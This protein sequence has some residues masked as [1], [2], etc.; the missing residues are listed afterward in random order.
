MPTNV[1]T[2]FQPFFIDFGYRGIAFFA[3]VYGVVS[4]YL[5]RLFRNGNN[6][7]TCL[8]TYGVYVLLMQF[9][10]EN[11]FMSMVFILQFIVFTLLFTQN[12]IRF[13]W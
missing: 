4:G 2:I 1:Y 7:G 8:Y 10:Q 5:Y 13:A 3:V 6:T 9:Y 12:K 11:V